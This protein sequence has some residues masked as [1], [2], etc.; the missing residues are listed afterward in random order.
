MRDGELVIETEDAVDQLQRTDGEEDDAMGDDDEVR[1]F[2]EPDDKETN[3]EVD[4]FAEVEFDE[5]YDED[6]GI[7]DDEL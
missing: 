2:D 1:D 3:D 6:S 5:H 7:S 4:E